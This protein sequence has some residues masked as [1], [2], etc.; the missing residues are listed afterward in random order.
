MTA[1][2]AGIAVGGPARGSRAVSRSSRGVPDP[3]TVVF[4]GTS[5][6]AVPSLEVLV[7][8]GERVARVVT[9]PDRP[10]GRGR[11]SE[12][13]PVKTAAERLGIPVLQ[14]ES[15]NAPEALQELSAVE[16]EFLAVVAFGQLLGPRLLALPRRG[17]VNVHPSLLP[18][19]R[20]PSP[21]A[22][23]LLCGDERA[24]VTTMLLDEGMDSGPIL[25]QEAGAVDPMRTRGELEEEFSRTGAR[26]LARTLRGLRE[27]GLQ[28]MPQDA[29][30]ATVSLRITRDLRAIPWRRPAAEVRRLIHALSPQPG[31]VARLRGRLVKVLRARE[32]DASGAPGTWL[33]CGPEGPVV[34]C[35]A[36]AVEWLEVQPEGKRAMTGAE[37]GRGA[38]AAVGETLEDPWDG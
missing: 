28:P 12:P 22:W 31:A 19:H 32:V 17:A 14:P 4:L 18:R 8:A 20:G 9:Q 23:T 29:K 6:F 10:R 37:F 11:R 34:A 24:G 30:A 25:L 2:S 7:A 1:R 21:I 33:G 15:V 3:G 5:A 38:G 26:L 36:G 27:G 16:P 13:S 35:A